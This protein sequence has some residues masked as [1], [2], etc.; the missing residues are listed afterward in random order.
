[1]RPLIL[2]S[3]FC[4][5]LSKTCAA[6]WPQWRGPMFNGS[7]VEKGLPT[8]WSESDGI[9]WKT[10]LPGLSGATPAVWGDSVFISSPDEQKN[11]LLLCVNRKDGSIRW[12]KQIAT[13]NI[14]QGKGNMASPSPVTDGKA[15]YVLY[16][17]GDIAALDFEGQIL[18][19]RNLGKDYGRFAIMW[20]YGSSPLLYDGKLY[21]QVL[22]RSPAPGDYP[23]IAGA[24]GDRESY[25]LALNPADGKTLWKHVRPTD[26]R[27]ESM[28]SYATPTP[29]KGADGKTQ[30]LIIGGDALTGHDPDSGKELWRGRGFNPKRGEWMRIVPSAVSAEGLAIGC[31]PK[32]EAML[33]FRTDMQGDITEKGVAWT[34]DEKRTPDVCTPA[35]YEG[36]LFVLHGDPPTGPTLT[37]L[38]PKTGVKKWQGNLDER[39]VVRASPTVA[40]GKIYIINEKGTVFVCSA[41]DQFQILSKIPMGGGEGTRASIAISDGQLFIRTTEALICVGK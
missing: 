7:S 39:V 36:K 9:K 22:Q 14:E 29:H 25:L 32:Q 38:D 30:L 16:G 20:I 28:E 40:D 19:Q 17:T 6:N 15:V 5:I 23:A 35:L 41:G 27:L 3:I 37:C 33:A 24:G 2:L 21:V 1:M 12:K 10:P 34:F 4:F 13:G 26:A 8:T 31:G 18:W 11:L